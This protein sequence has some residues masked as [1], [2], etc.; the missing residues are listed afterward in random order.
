MKRLGLVW[1]RNN[2]RLHD[3]EV[4]VWAH[5][6][7]DFVNHLYCFDPRQI[8]EKTYKCDFVKCDKHRLKFLIET[9]DN[10]RSSLVN[11]SS[12][13]LTYRDTPENAFKQLIDQYKTDYE[14]SIGFDKEF[15]QEDTDVENSI[16]QLARENN[17]HVKEFWASTLYHPDD[18]PYN[19]PKAFPDVYTHF[20]VALEKNNVRVRRLA[21]LPDTLKPPTN[22]VTSTPVPTLVD[23]GYPNMTAHASTVFPFEGGETTGLA[24][25]HRY[26]WEKELVKSYKATR[27]SL[28]GVDHTTKF[29][30]WLS[31]GSL[32][33]RKIFFEVK[34]YENDRRMADAGYWI[35]FELLW[36]DFFK[37]IAL[38]YGKRL[39][40][41]RGLR[42]E[43]YVWKH[44][45]VQFEAWRTG[46]T[47]VPFVDA[48][49]R[50]LLSTGWM[51]NRGRQNVASNLTK[52]F[53]IDWRY[54]AVWFE[55]ILVDHDV[56]SNYGNWIYVAGVG[57]DPRENRHFNMIKQ[58]FDYDADGVFVRTWCPELAR[59]PN[60]YIH[61]PWLAPV[62]VLR[63]A[64]VELGV[65]YPRP[66][67]TV[68]QWN[69]QA[70]NRRRSA[71]NQQ[72]TQQRGINFYFK[73]PSKRS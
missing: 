1:F 35:I 68:T 40:Y 37:F 21:N 53:N 3:N 26:I 69:Q 43:P 30:A 27:N 59:L 6:N 57:N 16:R 65:N 24:H 55:S 7:N 48:N 72:N 60:E 25:L 58:A 11:K 23:Y 41:G 22:G 32:S 56:C 29:S 9:V 70:Q 28:V 5:A 67:L 20:R 36:R 62:Q 42:E 64:G 49:M 19:N 12:A 66:L 71:Q 46:R 51:S 4:L 52:D 33:A 15:T 34:K 38:K 44:D 47:G 45:Q 17:V 18:I 14:I 13:L 39:F 73:N 2:L 10:L 54:G 63:E 50:E 31:N 61:T 8:T